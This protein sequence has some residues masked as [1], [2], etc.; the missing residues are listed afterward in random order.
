MQ[1]AMQVPSTGNPLDTPSPSNGAIS[2]VLARVPKSLDMCKVIE[3]EKRITEVE[4]VRETK[5]RHDDVKLGA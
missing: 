2:I 3:Y 5:P 4:R 1:I